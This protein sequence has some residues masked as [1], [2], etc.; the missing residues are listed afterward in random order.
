[1][2]SVLPLKVD[3]PKVAEGGEAPARSLERLLM[4]ARELLDADA[5]Y[6]PL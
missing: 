4:G 2:Q 3:P 1:M 5:Q 6:V